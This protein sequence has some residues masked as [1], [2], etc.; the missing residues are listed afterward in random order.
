MGLIGTFERNETC[1]FLT[2]H[3]IIIISTTNVYSAIN[4]QQ[5]RADFTIIVISFICLI[6]ETQVSRLIF[7]AAVRPFKLIRYEASWPMK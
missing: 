5:F 3:P 1:K 4:N 7:L 6:L 2:N